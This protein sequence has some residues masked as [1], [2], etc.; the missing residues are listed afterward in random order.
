M[1]DFDP[2]I[3]QLRIDAE[4]YRRELRS[5]AR[6]FDTT[7]IR[8]E[9]I[10]K[11]IGSSLRGT[12]GGVL[13]GLGA[14]Q[15]FQ[16]AKGALE[17]ASSLGEVS[18]QLG[19]TARDLQAFQYAGTQVG[20]SNDEVRQG[21]G[22]LTKT[23]GEAATGSVN[24]QKALQIVGFSLDEI[25]SGSLTAGEAIPRIAD[26]LSKIESPAQRAAVE[27]ELFGRA[28][29]KLD[30]LLS[31]GSGAINELRDAAE[32]LGIVLSDDQIQQ[33]DDTADK[34]AQIKTV[35][36]ANIASVVASNANSIVGLAQA[37]GT[38]TGQ[39]VNFLNSNPQLALGIIG[40]LAGSRL[41]PIGAVVGAAGGAYLGD[42][43][44]GAQIQ[45]ST[46][47]LVRRKRFDAARAKYLDAKML[48]AQGVQY[49]GRGPRRD[50]DGEV[51]AAAAEYVD[52]YR[53]FEAFLNQRGKKGGGSGGGTPPAL[54]TLNAPKP[55]AGAKGKSAE[56]VAKEQERAAEK[57]A[58]DEAQYQ[59]SLG[60]VR[61][62]LL[63][64]QA[65][66]TDTAQDRYAYEVARVDEERAALVRDLALEKDLSQA[67]KDEL[68]AAQDKVGAVRK[69]IAAQDRDA[70]LAR[71]TYEQQKLVSDNIIDELRYRG[72][73]ADSIKARRDLEIELIAARKQ[74]ERADLNSIIASNPAGSAAAKQAQGQLGTLDQ[75]YD[76]ETTLAGRRNETPGQA[77]LRDV[78]RS[79]EAINEDIDAIGVRGLQNLNDQLAEAVLGAKSLGSAFKNV[80]N[81]IIGD[82]IRIAIQQAIIKPL[83]KSLLGSGFLGF[84][85]GGGGRGRAQSAAD[86]VPGFASG[87]SMWIG[88]RAGVDQNTL[89]LNGAPIARVSRGEQLNI[90][91][92]GMANRGGRA[93]VAAPVTIAI[94]AR[95]ADSAAA[96]RLEG[97]L[98]QLR[99]E[100][101]NTIVATVKNAAERFAL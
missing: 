11:Q 19:V 10:G 24:A 46:D 62:A 96:A 65:Q 89:S 13:A 47:P 74:A 30:T 69:S 53:R 9:A 33:A 36:E 70:Q 40:G 45:G 59:D 99:A 78:N 88:G 21:L 82:L 58:R 80:A 94:D 66:L 51:K 5:T 95:G 75:R 93:S 49:D 38:L 68:L 23:L 91:P 12:L 44:Q 64:A 85:G 60:R 73:L 17:Y 29:Q 18:Q 34:L 52:E 84:L 32:S 67:K 71:E 79:A 41:G 20:L 98:A 16:V 81:Q 28:G 92:R 72:E 101:P 2:V 86:G 39:I 57:A 63:G 4:Q 6:E 1:P 8:M 83:A 25:K 3:V 100:L 15:L 43:I 7:A 48:R 87:G 14:A 54:G 22:K 31:G 56:A 26:Y 50:L 42:R 77:F 76:R 61:V 37:L 55:A 27:I 90:Q 35:L 97:A